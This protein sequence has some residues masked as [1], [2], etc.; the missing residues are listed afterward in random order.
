VANNIQSFSGPALNELVYGNVWGLEANIS[1]QTVSKE[2]LKL[3]SILGFDD[4]TILKYDESE[5]WGNDTVK[6]LY[7]Q[8]SN[9]L[10]FS[11][12]LS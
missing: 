2:D 10:S 12:H 5:S 6:K 9:E 8:P 3:I 7:F 11:S 1:C 4:Y